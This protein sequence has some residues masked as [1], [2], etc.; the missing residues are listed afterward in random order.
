M[1]YAAEIAADAAYQQNIWNVELAQMEI[2]AAKEQAKAELGANIF[3][4]ILGGVSG[5]F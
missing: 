3:G 4:T 2:D 1:S 5:L